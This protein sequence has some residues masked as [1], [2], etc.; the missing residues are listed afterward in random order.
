MRTRSPIRRVAVAA[1]AL[2]STALA[3]TGCGGGT[4]DTGGS[5]AEDTGASAAASS[6]P[7][8]EVDQALAD[9]VPADISSDGVITVGTD[10]TYAPSEFLAEDGSTIVGFDVDL[11]SLVAAKL[12]LE[13]EFQTAP[14]D[15]I[16]AGVGSGRYEVGVSSFT[17]NP[18][19]LAQATMI[20][21]F[22]AGTQWATKAGN[23]EGVDPDDACGLSIAVQR[24]TVQVDDITARSEACEAAGDPAI[25]I[26][27]YEGQDQ[28]TAAV[29]SGKDVA[30]LADSPVMAYAVQQT[31][32]QLELLGDVYDAA[33]YGYVVPQDQTD[34]AQALADAVTALVE[35]GSYQQVLENWG[36]EGGAIDAPAV[37][38]TV[39]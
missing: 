21:Y 26:D 19:R 20:S 4:S 33:P 28:A 12:G 13:A 2:T 30:V 8:V 35:D 14:F 9:R 24:G 32:G 15:S 18:D 37:N 6:L 34:F 7:G 38:P 16:I 25:T 5:A 17:I 3:V 39:G 10:S 11:F 29:V 22:N 27:Q 31:N 36:V 1:V 23:P